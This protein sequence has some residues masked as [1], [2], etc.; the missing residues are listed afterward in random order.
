MWK[1]FTS[2]N[3]DF[4]LHFFPLAYLLV[5]TFHSNIHGE[6]RIP[7]QYWNTEHSTIIISLSWPRIVQPRSRRSPRPLYYNLLVKILYNIIKYII[8]L[9]LYYTVVKRSNVV[10]RRLCYYKRIEP[11]RGCLLDREKYQGMPG[12]R[13]LGWYLDGSRRVTGRFTAPRGL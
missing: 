4:G 11:L 6:T 9:R 7:W 5:L 8:L 2:T 3:N 13:D 12:Y 10:H 1:Y